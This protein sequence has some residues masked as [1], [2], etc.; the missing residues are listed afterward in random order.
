MSKDGDTSDDDVRTPEEG[1]PKPETFDS[2]LGVRDEP[3]VGEAKRARASILGQMFPQMQP[4]LDGRYRLGP[5]IGA[6]GLGRVRKAYDTK[7]QRHVAIKFLKQAREEPETA[8]ALE[9]EA[10]V[11]ARLQHPNIVAVHDVGRAD[12][13]LYLTMELIDGTP[14]NAWLSKKPAWQQVVAVMKQAAEG[15]AAAHEAGVVH[16]DFKPANVMVDRAGRVRV[17]DFG[18]A[19]EVVWTAD[20]AVASEDVAGIVHTK[21]A[22]T[23]PYMAPEQFDGQVSAA[24]DQ[25]AFC[26]S[27]YEGV[28][29][30]KPWRGVHRGIGD[31]EDAARVEQA[32]RKQ[33]VDATLRGVILRG[34]ALDPAH[35]F[36]DMHALLQ[37]LVPRRRRWPWVAAGVFAAAGVAVTG[38]AMQP[39]EPCVGRGVAASSV[40]S[41]ADAPELR[42]RFKTPTL[43]DDATE[44]LDAYV[45]EWNALDAETCQAEARGELSPAIAALRA[46]CLN[47]VST[48]VEATLGGITAQRY[49][50]SRIVRAVRSATSLASCVNHDALLVG[51]T[52]EGYDAEAGERIQRAIDVAYVYSELG[53]HA[54]WR[55]ELVAINAAIEPRGAALPDELWLVQHLGGALVQSGRFEEARALLMPALLEAKRHP[56]W[57]L[58][59]SMLQ[60]QLARLALREGRI[61]EA[62]LLI[63]VA[64]PALSTLSAK[65]HLVVAVA[66]HAVI[67]TEAGDS[68]RALALLDRADAVEADVGE[69]AEGWAGLEPMRTSRVLGR[70]GAKLDLKA[71]AEAEAACREGL[72]RLE[73]IGSGDAYLRGLSLNNMALAIRKQGRFDEAVP[74]FEQAAAQ[75]E[76]YGDEEGAAKTWVN[77][78]NAYEGVGRHAEGLVAYG[79]AERLVGDRRMGAALSMRFN[80]AI[81]HAVARSWQ[82]AADDYDVALELSGELGEQAEVGRYDIEVGLGVALAEL[83]ESARAR[84]VLE[85]ALGR[86]TEH[87]DAYT[88]AELRLWL[89]PLLESSPARVQM[90]VDAKR[91]AAR[92]GDPELV[93]LAERAG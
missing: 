14:L 36:S 67:A 52:E 93:A 4:A 63:S 78:A 15:L 40:W 90:V 25:F 85:R 11:L 16:R 19:R 17:V 42:Q 10:Q 5:E 86:E 68:E 1:R 50:E 20:E 60:V 56:S 28:C 33:G 22:G 43:A 31:R 88:Q 77:L 9:R 39:P 70:C 37:E 3:S 7:L 6:G 79:E 38:Y 65:Q 62:E 66:T 41:S 51:V 81:S 69:F 8:S 46:R 24:S 2:G 54:R 47:R 26:T 49:D 21:A 55:E 29:G 53:D 23:P 82:A 34:L 44:Q 45:T 18:L 13:E 61:Q 89:A 84:E 83:G 74:L 71:Y 30:H 59:T 32:L 58:Q 48:R 64:E 12:G 80:R 87:A 57:V 72:R 27:L 75:K 91:A 73:A 35:R 92:S 76:A